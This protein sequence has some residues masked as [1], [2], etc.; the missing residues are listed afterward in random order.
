MSRLFATKGFFSH[1]WTARAVRSNAIAQA[2]VA[3]RVMLEIAPLPRT[4]FDPKSFVRQFSS[5][6]DLLKVLKREEQEEVENETTIMPE[7]LAQ[8]KLKLESNWKIV[9]DKAMTSMFLKNKKVQL[10]FHCQDSIPTDIGEDYMDGDDINGFEE[11]EPS[12]V[13]FTVTGK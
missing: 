8:L 9:E 4:V 7:P 2:G 1:G 13:R 5:S 10:S 6:S 11:E 3:S 12:A